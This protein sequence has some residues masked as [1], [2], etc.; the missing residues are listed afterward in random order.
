MLHCVALTS[1]AVRIHCIQESTSLGL[2][3]C[4][5]VL[6]WAT[7]LYYT[8]HVMSCHVMSCHVMSCHVMSYVAVDCRAVHALWKRYAEGQTIQV[9]GVPIASGTSFHTQAGGTLGMG[10]RY[11]PL[12]PPPLLIG[13]PL[14]SLFRCCRDR[15]PT[16]IALDSAVCPMAS[17]LA[18][19]LASPLYQSSNGQQIHVS[20][21]DLLSYL[22]IIKCAAACS[23]GSLTWLC[24]HP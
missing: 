5:T 7:H 2:E 10:V 22:I 17:S 20:Q 14:H 6:H 1:S 21:D 24:T 13:P 23:K 19:P 3:L 18:P 11:C 12:P 15:T 4:F 8:C 9:S 16:A